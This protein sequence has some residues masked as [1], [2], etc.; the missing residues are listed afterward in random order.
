MI[1][2]GAATIVKMKRVCLKFCTFILRTSLVRYS[3]AKLQVLRGI[4]R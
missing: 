3:I 2:D 1:R 4:L